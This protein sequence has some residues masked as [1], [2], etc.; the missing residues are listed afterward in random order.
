MIHVK[1]V[2]TSVLIAIIFILGSLPITYTL[3]DKVLKYFK[4]RTTFDNCPGLPTIPG[5]L[6]HAILVA[7]TV[8]VILL[9]KEKTENPPMKIE[10]LNTQFEEI[11]I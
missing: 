1:K 2:Y 3:S 9:Y 11:D 8:Y 6:I 10:K 5:L 4:V 7:L